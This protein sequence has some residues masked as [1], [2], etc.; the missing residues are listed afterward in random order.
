MQVIDIFGDNRFDKH[1]K[2]REASRGIVI[3]NNQ[4]LLSYEVNRNQWFIPGGGKENGESNL[5]CCIR[6]V[7]EETGYLVSAENE[8]LIINEYYE[9]YLY[10]SH[11]Y[12][13]D[14]VG[15]TEQNLTSRELE[16]GLEPRWVDFKEALNIFAKHHDYAKSDEMKRGEYLREYKALLAYLEIKMT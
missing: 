7:K 8:Y 14:V 4:I 3:N 16:A 13:C 6:E 2:F 1:T 9:E 12:I 5:E 10:L 11:Y 15:V